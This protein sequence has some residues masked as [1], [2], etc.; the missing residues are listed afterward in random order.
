MG[1]EEPEPWP[2]ALGA[3]TVRSSC[4][5]CGGSGGMYSRRPFWPRKVLYRCARAPLTIWS[6][7]ESTCD[8]TSCWTVMTSRYE[9]TR[10]LMRWMPWSSVRRAWEMQGDIGEM[11][12]RYRG[13]AG[14]M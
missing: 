9:A 14:E 5:T 7:S 2:A 10:S 1:L 4:I 3:V 6:G 11:Q 12:G 8:L 13:D